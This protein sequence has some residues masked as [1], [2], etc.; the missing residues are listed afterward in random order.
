MRTLLGLLFLCFFGSPSRSAEPPAL[1]PSAEEAQKLR[2]EAQ[3]KKEELEKEWEKAKVVELARYEKMFGKLPALADK[4]FFW[5]LS[6]VNPQPLDKFTAF[7]DKKLSEPVLVG[8][9]YWTWL[10][11]NRSFRP[12]DQ[13]EF[14][15]EKYYLRGRWETSLVY[16][17]WNAGIYL[18]RAWEN[19]NSILFRV[20]PDTY[21]AGTPMTD[22][23]VARILNDVFQ[24]DP[25]T[26]PNRIKYL[27]LPQELKPG[28]SFPTKNM[29][30]VYVV[31]HWASS[32]VGFLSNEDLCVICHKTNF[33]RQSG[34]FSI[35]PFWLH[36]NLYEKD[37]K[38]WVAPPP[39]KDTPKN[40]K[41]EEIE[42]PPLQDLLPPMPQPAKDPL[43]IPKKEGIKL[44]PL[45]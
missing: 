13:L 3:K 25:Q 19:G 2:E 22:K 34:L 28:T 16:Y 6:Y 35:D 32:I 5:H 23:E 8:S 10:F 17:E 21:K 42:L 4:K 31:T 27:E 40:P 38:T 30:D 20:K 39:A 45:R 37:G 29:N 7:G 11:L 1:K 41:K 14:P 12:P 33:E 18:I 15:P 26:I 24:L 43:K 9:K 44:P 36:E